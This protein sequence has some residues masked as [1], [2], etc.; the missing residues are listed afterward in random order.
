MLNNY[1][2]IAHSYDFLSRLIFQN[3]QLDAQTEQLKHLSAK[4][5]ILIVGGGT[6]WILREIEQLELI[7]LEITYVEISAKMMKQAKKKTRSPQSIQFVHCAIEDFKTDEQF[8]IIHTAFLFDNFAL[9]RM[10]N[11]FK[12]LD[13]TLKPGGLWL[14]ADFDYSTQNTSLWKKLMLK[15]MYAF[16]RKIAQV[17]AKALVDTDKC[18]NHTNYK[19][20]HQQKYYSSFIEA[21]VYQKPD[22]VKTKASQA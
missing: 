12:Q 22:T 18:F 17:E 21:T 15:V 4:N 20:V 1:D 10:E 2:K 5:K 8:D 9:Q 6:G 11:V 14:F 7:G 16:F 13:A 19:K 3:A